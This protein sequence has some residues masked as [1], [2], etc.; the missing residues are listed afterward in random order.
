MSI[1]KN[2]KAFIAVSVAVLIV[3]AGVLF[4]S[5]ARIQNTYTL[6][7]PSGTMLA[8]S[9]HSAPDYVILITFNAT[10]TGTL[11][12]SLK[13]ST[14]AVAWVTS[15]AILPEKAHSHFP[16]VTK[17]PDNG[18]FNVPITGKGNWVIWFIMSGPGTVTITAP[19]EITQLQ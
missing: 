8:D 1:R 17:Y 7:I 5:V 10:H 9:H 3:T 14:H 12:G 11:I 2:R 4:V 6:P 13:A 16:N 19:I 15:G 18:T